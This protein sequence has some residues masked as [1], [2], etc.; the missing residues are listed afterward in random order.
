MTQ[1]REESE[2]ED[3][4]TASSKQKRNRKRL[5]KT[6][7]NMQGPG[8]S[9]ERDGGRDGDARRERKGQEKRL[10]QQCVKL[11]SGQTTDPGSSEDTD[12]DGRQ[13]TTLG[14]PD[15]NYSKPKKETALEEARGSTGSAED[16]GETDL[17]LLR[18][19]AGRK[20]TAEC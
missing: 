5:M 13:R 12:Q 16:E 4:P 8:S 14:I 10:E 9:R 20:R 7:Q 6:G 18:N 15:A 3:I 11:V 17:S 1:L 19:H 2:L